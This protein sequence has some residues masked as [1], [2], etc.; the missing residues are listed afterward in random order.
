MIWGIL[1]GIVLG[2]FFKPQID[3]L[4]GGVIRMIRNRR[5]R[6]DRFDGRY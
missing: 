3:K 6:N 5:S 4:V 1:I 2:Y